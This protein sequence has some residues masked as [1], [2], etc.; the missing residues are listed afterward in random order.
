MLI[1]EVPFRGF[2]YQVGEAKGR[3]ILQCIQGSILDVTLDLRPGSLAYDEYITH[4]L[5]EEDQA[6]IVIPELCA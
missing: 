6:A 5:S 4:M 1:Y 3:K 2:H